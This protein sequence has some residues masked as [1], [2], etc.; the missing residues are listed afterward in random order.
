MS[1]GRVE[2]AKVA[3]ANGARET[4]EGQRGVLRQANEVSY[5]PLNSLQKSIDLTPRAPSAGP[6]GGLAVALPAGTTSLHN[7]RIVH[8]CRAVSTAQSHS[9]CFH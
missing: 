1:Y 4:A 5:L 9:P 6:I 2:V 3:E 8:T 7:T